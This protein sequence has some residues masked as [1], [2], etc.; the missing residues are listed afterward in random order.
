MSKVLVAGI[1]YRNL[2]D[3]S[4]GV[5]IADQ[6]AGR[7]W[8][9]DVSVEDLS[10]NPVAVAQRLEDD[11]PA[12]RF[13]RVIFVAAVSRPSRLPGTVRAYRWDGV[14][15]PDDEIHRAVCDAVTG[16]IHLDN[17][18]IVARHLGALPD[19]VAVV[20]VEP[21]VH[22][23]GDA[24]S[25]PVADAVARARE[26]VV[27]LATDPAAAEALPLAALGGAIAEGATRG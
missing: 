10:Y 13:A 25:A 21:L 6:L 16:V 22:E 23:F 11:P 5:A 14:L 19:A 4:A 17:T 27:T 24:F 2:R 3:H 20:E 9:A 1:G 8:P 26:L 15:P 7:A 12:R 18:L